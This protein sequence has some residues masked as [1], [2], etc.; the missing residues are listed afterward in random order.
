MGS[1]KKLSI[2]VMGL[3]L[4]MMLLVAGCGGSTPEGKKEGTTPKPE[5]GGALLKGTVYLP[6]MGGHIAVANV[7]ID[8]SNSDEPI[9]IVGKLDK[10]H[11]GNKEEWATHDV[12]VD[13][14]DNNVAYSSSYVKDSNGKIRVAKIDLANLEMTQEELLDVHERLIEQPMYCAS[15]Q[16]KDMFLPVMMGYEGWIDVVNKESLELKHRV[17]FDDDQI[18]KDYIFAHGVH[19]PDMK[20][21]LLSLNETSKNLAKKAPPRGNP[22]FLLYL[23]DMDELTQGKIKIVK[24]SSVEADPNSS[25]AFRQH[26]T[27][28]GKYLLQSGRD[29]ALVI[30]A[31]TLETVR[32]IDLP[33]EFDTQYEC[34]DVIATADNKY[35]VLAVRV[36]LMVEGVNDPIMDGK[37]FLVDIEKG[38]LI[39]NGT[40]VCRGCHDEYPSLKTKTSVLCG[41]DAVWEK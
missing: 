23:L 6:G 33:K 24:S 15:G 39:G 30:D 26:F 1:L 38:T 36:P 4:V 32:K 7:E 18:T 25:I 35:A 37:I 19:T 10:I 11:L 8:P 20:H 40:S 29:R 28:D 41:I 14:E 21:F 31:D 13:K 17:F 12:R 22:N 5:E 16:S 9:K 2:I 27:T 34:H 3:F